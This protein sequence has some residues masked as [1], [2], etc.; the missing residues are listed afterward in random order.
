[1]LTMCLTN[2]N[3]LTCAKLGN[4]TDLISKN[5]V[6]IVAVTESHL[7]PCIRNAAIAIPHYDILRNDVGNVQKHG[8]CVYVHHEVQVDNV[9]CPM[10]NVLV[11]RLTKYNVYVVVVYRPPSY[12]HAQNQELLCLL[13]DVVRDREA[14]VVGDFNLPGISWDLHV[15]GFTNQGSPMERQF[16]DTFNLLGLTQWITNVT[17][18]RSGNTLDLLLS[19]ES[20]RVGD[21]S[22]Q[23]PIPGSDHCVI[24]YDYIF[25]VEN[26]YDA[27]IPNRVLWHKGNY[28]KICRAL[29]QVDWEFELAYLNSCQSFKRFM[30][31]VT[32]LVKEYV[33]CKPPAPER[34]SPPWRVRPPGELIRR[35]QEA[36]N[37][38]KAA[39]RH[40][41]RRSPDASAAFAA[42]SNA[43]R[44]CLLFSAHS[45]SNYEDNLV[46]DWKEAPKLLHSYVRSK[47]SSPVTVGPLRLPDGSMCTD[48][49]EMSEF[50]AGAFGSVYRADIPQVQEE[51]Q[52][53]DDLI[54][55]LTFSQE[56]VKALL[57]NIDGSSAMGPD[58]LHPLVLKHCADAIAYPLYV[59]F[60]RS[61]SKGI[62]PEAWKISTVIPIFK[63]GNRY[64]P[65]N[66]R[67]ISLTSVCCKTM[68]RLICRHITGFLEEHNILS[69]HQFG[70][71]A[72]RSTVDQLLLVYE[73]V[74]RDVDSGRLVDV[75]LFDYSKAFDVVR[76]QILLA[77]LHSIGVQG[78]I[79]RWVQQFLTNRL[80]QV[81]VKGRKSLPRHVT[82][83]VPQGSVLGPL[84]F[85]IYINHIASKL[86]CRFKIFADDLKIYA[87]VA[88][89]HLIAQD[90]HEAQVQT[91]ID[92]LYNTSESWGL[93]INSDK[94]AVLRF[95]KGTKD[96]TRP[97]YTLNGHCLSAPTSHGD[98]GVIVDNSLKFHEHIDSLSQRVAGLC[99]SFLKALASRSPKLMLFLLT[100][101]IRPVLEYCSCLWHTGYIGDLRKLERI[102]RR[103]T[104][105]IQ[106]FGTLPYSERLNKLGLFS[107]EGRLTRA[108]LIQYWKIFHGKSYITPHS[109]FV[110]PQT[111][112]R[113]HPFKIMVMRANTDIRQRFFSQ[114]CVNL[115]NSLPVDVVTAP[116]LQSFKRCLADAIP[117]KLVQYA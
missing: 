89:S 38:Y 63:K 105:R 111:N 93:H 9:L 81:S 15:H 83:G 46:E 73:E 65:L 114:R 102:Q 95:S 49:Q 116:D 40:F 103:W 11:F 69:D 4:L 77:K 25:E 115:W 50:L 72:G 32:D 62:V 60:S 58:E 42:F 52:T 19:T 44:R 108:D 54:P 37:D 45:Q 79:L 106:D 94:C 6:K 20:D 99:H 80:M 31:I 117:D 24:V 59:I 51:H 67:P 16:V 10:T 86:K 64:D 2:L 78:D 39:R 57:V 48:P 36:W 7:I 61:L 84:L 41:G 34:I 1:M 97:Y 88:T 91:D 110:Q 104:K 90:E 70:F 53:S 98:L 28:P 92:T 100:T 82:S 21:I 75:I 96:T 17:F 14:I 101:H 55:P 29:S 68:E 71:R 26:V 12:T 74:S 47:K 56:E 33:P 109:M 113:G 107:I 87:S 35:R 18:P 66:Y 43:N 23:P 76:H 22:V 8:V 13:D 112:T 85:L 27:T 30:S 5:N 3:G